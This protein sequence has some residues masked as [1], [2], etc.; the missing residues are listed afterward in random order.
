MILHDFMTMCEVDVEVYSHNS[1]VL[2]W[3][4]DDPR[5]NCTVL[6]FGVIDDN[7]IW[8][9]INEDEVKEV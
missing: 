2:D 8:V 6:A 5:Y 7:T 4:G 3:F 1:P 9:D